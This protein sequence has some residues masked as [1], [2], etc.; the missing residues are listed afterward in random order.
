MF[1]RTD[2]KTPQLCLAKTFGKNTGLFVIAFKY[3]N[4]SGIYSGNLNVKEVAV[5]TEFYRDRLKDAWQVHHVVI[6][7]MLGLARKS[8]ITPSLYL[9]L[10]F[11][12]IEFIL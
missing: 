1:A 2:Q 3:N 8:S 12:Y 4:H 10:F 11:L 9:L 6:E 5:L 7:G